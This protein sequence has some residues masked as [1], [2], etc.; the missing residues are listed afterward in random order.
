[1]LPLNIEGTI[2]RATGGDNLTRTRLG[3]ETAGGDP[4]I[5]I[6]SSGMTPELLPSQSYAAA[7][8]T[9]TTSQPSLTA[10]AM[11]WEL[12]STYSVTSTLVDVGEII[13]VPS[14]SSPQYN[15]SDTYD[16]AGLTDRG[17]GLSGKDPVAKVVGHIMNIVR[18]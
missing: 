12:S 13:P 15:P 14:D 7:A 6:S 3:G 4:P 11:S 9:T 18:G 17:Q 8:Q 16:S 5:S 10:P 1:V 2:T